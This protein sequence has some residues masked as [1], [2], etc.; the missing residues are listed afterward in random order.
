MA[1]ETD[2]V[3]R[4]RQPRAEITGD[5][6]ALCGRLRDIAASTAENA[7]QSAAMQADAM[8]AKATA[9]AQ[10]EYQARLATAKK[11]LE[12]QLNSQM[13]NARL[14]D[15]TRLEVQQWD[16]LTQV[17]DQA[18]RTIASMRTDNPNRYYA[19]IVRF[20]RTAC[21]VLGDKSAVARANAADIEQLKQS[22]GECGIEVE[23]ADNQ[24]AAGVIVSTSNGNL[25]VDHSI[26]GRRQRFELEL[27][28]AA[29]EIL[30][31]VDSA[32]MSQ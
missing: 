4:Q 10:G 31:G 15:R 12:K 9:Q 21:D 13:Q 23:S 27:R 17:L 6:E 26:G 1:N 2:A 7:L 19:A 3:N 8:I 18:A 32:R 20:V 30:F 22:L 28:L 14:A 11:K 29:R 16:V 25:V 24:P 5:V